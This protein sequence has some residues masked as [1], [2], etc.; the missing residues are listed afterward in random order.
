MIKTFP[1]YKQFSNVTCGIT[2]IKIIAK[3]Y[4]KI[5]DV[6]TFYKRVTDKGLSIY[7]LCEISEELGLRSTTFELKI[8]DLHSFEKPL[9]IHWNS[10]H[11]VVL[12]KI[13]KNI[14]YVSD[15]VKGLITYSKK[16][17]SENWSINEEEEK[18]YVLLLEPSEKFTRLKNAKSNYL[19]AIEFLIRHLSPYKKSLSQLLSVM[20]II[21]LI[22]A[23]L[24]FITRSI[25]DVGIGTNDL[26]FI[27][28]VLIANLALLIFRSIGEWIRASISLHIAS[29]IKISIIT[30]YLIKVFSLPV[31]YIE[32]ILSGDIIQRSRD[33][34]RIQEFVSNSAI[35]IVMSL[36]IISIYS[37]I[38]FIFNE[39]LFYIF[40]VATILYVIWIM[41]FYQIRKKMDIKYYEL[42]G[43]NQS[44]WMEILKNFEDIKLNNYTLNRR[45]KWEKI[46]GNLYDVGIK[47]LNIDRIQRLGAD[48]INGVKDIGITFYSAYLVLEGNMTFGTLISIQF[49]LGQTSGPVSELI[50]L[51]NLNLLLLAF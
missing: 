37:V 25:I 13:K 50:L 20:V 42:M 36:L 11:Y 51:S 1:N 22:Y 12:Y 31:D 29:R 5:I 2:C 23:S 27:T 45:W 24:P 16:E 3:Y 18:G 15:P 32:S 43:E 28:I 40:I 49:I 19:S 9:I 17:F 35:S 6:S 33:Q 10:N 48:F 21:S 39:N 44:S 38:L 47:L 8:N 7:D 30:D 41:L 26:N 4:K 14:F 34:E 46:Q